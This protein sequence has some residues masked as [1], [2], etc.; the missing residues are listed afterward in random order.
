MTSGRRRRPLSAALRATRDV[1]VDLSELR[2]ADSVADDRPRRARAAPARAGADA[3]AAPSAAAR[4]AAHRA[5]RAAPA[6]VRAARRAAARRRVVALR[7]SPF[8][9]APA[10]VAFARVRLLLVVLFIVV[11]IAELAIIIQVGE[12]LGVWWTIALLIADSM[13][14]SLLM[15][16][17]GRAAWRRF[18]AAVQAGRPPA[19]EVAD[20]VLIIFGGA[21]LLTPGFIS[22]VARPALPAAAHA[23]AHPARCSCAGRWRRSRSRWRGGAAPPA[24]RRR[25]ARRATWTAPPSSWTASGSAGDDRPGRRGG[26]RRRHGQRDLRV[27]ATRAA[28]LYGLARIG[29]AREPEGRGHRAR[30][31]VRRPR[32]RRGA[33][34]A[35]ACPSRRARRGRRSSWPGCGRAVEQPLTRWRTA[36]RADGGDGFAL[37][38]LA[39]GDPAGL[40]DGRPA[41]RGSA[42]WPATTSRAACAGRS[43][44]AAASAAWTASASA[45]THGATRTGSASS[46]PAPSRRGPAAGASAALAAVRPA[47]ARHHA[48]EAVW[49]ALWEPEGLLP[50][51]E[52]R[53]STTY[54]ARRAHAPGRARAVAGEDGEGDGWARRGAGEVL[55]GSSLDLGELRLDCA[56][57]RWHLEGRAGRRPVRRDPPRRRRVIRAVVSD[58]G[59]VL[60]APLLHGLPAHPGRRRRPARGVRRGDARRDRRPTGRTRSTGWSGA[61]SPSRRSSPPSSASSPRCSAARS[62]C[63]ASA[64]AISARST[65]TTSCSPTTAACTRRGVRLAMLT[66]NVREWEP[67]WRAKLPDRRDLRDRRRLGLRRRAQARSADLRARARAA[68]S[69]PPRRARSSTTSSA[70]ST[71]RASWAS[72][73]CTSAS[74][75]QAVAELDALL[76]EGR[77]LGARRRADRAPI[78]ERLSCRSPAGPSSRAPGTPPRAPSSARARA[79]AARSPAPAPRRRRR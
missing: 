35:A 18:T 15:R 8:A 60:T 76:R 38:F 17:Q 28:E 48:D 32:A 50:L 24:A 39:I 55:C 5:G 41:S 27:R 72:T 14:G 37:E 79:R 75:A 36:S 16:S 33:A 69:C 53:L 46:S 13:L 2:F 40:G 77:A 22:D 63:T 29:L 67:H 9:H 57:F 56:F 42:A 59:G 30:R 31:A 45:A 19:R 23:R 10:G 12:L 65:P 52:A 34:P 11:P 54:D 21:L 61:R 71:P 58:F 47:G 7:R 3:V 73:A 66:N 78:G 49:A 51:E 1:I 4:Q 62:P 70:T 74:T 20:G 44:P 6:A 25:P 68:R 43:A 26:A 64:S